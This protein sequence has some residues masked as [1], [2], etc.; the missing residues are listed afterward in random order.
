M[1]GAV[2]RKRGNEELGP[3]LDEGG[4]NVLQVQAQEVGFW[5]GFW[6][7]WWGLCGGW[8]GFWELWGEGGDCGDDAHG[9]GRGGVIKQVYGP[10]ALQQLAVLRIADPW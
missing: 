10:S 7:R 9:W 6:V 2:E 5:M 4:K 1:V 3:S 8:W